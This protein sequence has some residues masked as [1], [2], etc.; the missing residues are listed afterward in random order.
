M[1]GPG[2][3]LTSNPNVYNNSRTSPDKR[4]FAVV[5]DILSE[6]PIEGLS[7]NLASI[8]LND[9]PFV[10]PGVNDIIKPRKIVVNTTA[11]STTISHAQIGEIGNLTLN[12][13]SGLSLGGRTVTI[14]GAGGSG[15]SIASMTAGTYT[16]TTSSAFFTTAMATKAAVMPDYLRIS[17]AGANG[18]DLV[19]KINNIA[20]STS[21]TVTNHG[22][23]TVSNAD[24]SVDF[25]ARITAIS[26]N[27]ATLS[28]AV[29]VTLSNAK[30]QISGLNTISG[31]T[32]DLTNFEKVEVHFRAGERNQE[33]IPHKDSFGSAATTTSLNINLEQADLRN[34]TEFSSLLAN[35]NSILQ[36]KSGNEG[37]AEDT[38]V[39]SA[40]AGVSNPSEIDE[41]HLTFKFPGMSAMKPSSGAK[42]AS[43]VELQ[44][45]F[46]YSTD[47]GSSFTSELLFG[48]TAA[49]VLARGGANGDDKVTHFARTPPNTGYI[50]PSEPQ[51]TEFS[52]EFIINTA[53][54]Q[55]YDTWRVRVRRITALNFTAGSFR[56]K[57]DCI[58]STIESVVKDKLRYP[59]TSYISTSFNAADFDGQLPERAYLLKGL[60]IQVPTNYLTRDETGGAASYVRNV[61]SGATESS[62]QNW[63]GNF[64]GDVTTFNRT[65][66]NYEKVYCDNPVWVF[67]DLLVN[68]RYGLGQFID[69][70]N[71]DKYGLFQLAKYCDELVPD[72]EGGYE[73]RF[74]TNV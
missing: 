15:S 32:V 12:N 6:G 7:N 21:A 53:Q 59:Y 8:F 11:N 20:S 49:Q 3:N 26:G 30:A 72:G 57:N 54:Y 67:Y 2:K 66:N 50:K 16:V 52:E 58:L 40:L 17:G 1:P 9:V 14:E 44:I 45:F 55:P 29:P 33:Y 74:T 13:K 18:T 39:S 47:G 64:R 46:E 25:N 73:P 31:S 42:E 23:T 37:T 60:K 61:T 35:Y 68:E 19:T 24:I 65:S 28:D 27:N 4:Q 34:V 69:K 70:S 10:D 38:V 36:E 41:V 48:P 56:H 63:D 71:I 51:Y 62:Y 43:F 5:Y 22:V